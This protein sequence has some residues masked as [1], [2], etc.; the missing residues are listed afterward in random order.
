[1]SR[2]ATKRRRR[3]ICCGGVGLQTDDAREED[4]VVDRPAMAAAPR[5]LRAGYE[6]G[7]F[8]DGDERDDVRAARAGKIIF[9]WATN[10]LYRIY[11]WMECPAV[12]VE[13]MRHYLHHVVHKM[14]TE[15]EKKKYRTL[16]KAERPVVLFFHDD[17]CFFSNDAEAWQ[18]GDDGTARRCMKKGDGQGIMVSGIICELEGLVAHTTIEISKGAWWNS[19]RLLSWL[20]KDVFSILKQ[21]YDWVR[22]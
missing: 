20:A 10:V 19:D 6:K 22:T 3:N 18:W 4:L 16:P 9:A 12:Y 8:V 1:M 2:S 14:P 13:K 11:V 15:E 21:K 5:V 17:A 7:T